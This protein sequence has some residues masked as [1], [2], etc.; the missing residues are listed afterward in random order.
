MD[1]F[2]IVGGGVVGLSLAYELAGAGRR[3]RLVDRSEPGREASWAGAGI[4]PPAGDGASADPLTLLA[5]LSGRLHVEWAERLRS[6]T[7]IDNGFRRCG[8]IYLALSDTEALQLEAAVADWTRRQ[9]ACEM[10]SAGEANRLE[11]ALSDNHDTIRLACLVPGECQ[12]RN[13]RHLKALIAAC[14]LRGVEITPTAEVVGLRRAGARVTHVQTTRGEFAAGRVCLT[15]G[16]WSGVLGEQLGLA[17]PVKPIRGQIVLLD[18]GRPLLQRIINVGPRYLVPRPD[19]LVLVGSTEEDV[20]FDKQT[21]AEATRNL[22]EFA[23]QLTPGLGAARIERTW[24]GLRPATRDGL[25]YLGRVPDYDNLFIAAG[26]YRGGLFLSPGTAV[27][28]AQLMQEGE[29]AIDLASFAV[30]R[31]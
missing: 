26:H 25:P 12:L 9:V 11:P 6:E 17:M 29:A 5:A 16:A 24:A 14:T 31:D 28:M 21:T 27:V 7:G 22:L 19:G 20:G 8:A 10:I 2:L 4:L 13:P 30:D 18:P 15:T 1:D 3:V 23:L